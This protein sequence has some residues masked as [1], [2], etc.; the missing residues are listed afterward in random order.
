MKKHFIIFCIL[1]SLFLINVACDSANESDINYSNEFKK[2]ENAFLKENV[3]KLAGRWKVEK[4]H[5][6]PNEISDIFK[7]DT[8]LSNVGFIT[9]EIIEKEM[10]DGRI[11]FYFN[12]N[13]QINQKNI[14]FRSSLIHTLVYTNS[15]FTL[16]EVDPKYFTESVTNHADLPYEYHLLDGYFF[17]DNYEIFF[18]EDGKSAI[19]KGFNRSAKVIVLTKT[20]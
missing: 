18:S 8:I 1:T 12:A 19:W 17:K 3:P 7:K 15:F 4:M 20:H 13:F 16:I 10:E 6:V 5:I 2:Q 14:P 11:P 9:F